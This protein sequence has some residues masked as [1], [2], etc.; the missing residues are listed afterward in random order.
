M[1]DDYEQI[2]QD[3]VQDGACGNDDG[4]FHRISVRLD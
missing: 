4:G 1:E 2:I 3:T